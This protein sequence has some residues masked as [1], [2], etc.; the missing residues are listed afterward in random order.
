MLEGGVCD[1]GDSRAVAGRSQGTWSGWG[2]V[3]GG[4][5]RG[6]G[7]CWGMGIAFRWRQG[8]SVGGGG[9]GGNPPPPPHLEAI[10]W[11]V[12]SELVGGRRLVNGGWVVSRWH[13]RGKW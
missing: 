13:L 4:W 8:R 3:T 12:R 1:R 10:P 7:W 5:K 9:E 6:W 2:A 11:G